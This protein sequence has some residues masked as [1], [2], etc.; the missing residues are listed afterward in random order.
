MLVVERGDLVF[1]F[2]F[3]PVNSFSDYRVGAY[4]PGPY[5]AR[6]WQA[7]R[8]KRIQHNHALLLVVSTMLH[9]ALPSPARVS[10][11]TLTLK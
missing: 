10:F 5:K 1:V 3:H 4:L 7:L 2:N 9:R 8:E 11:Q 6:V